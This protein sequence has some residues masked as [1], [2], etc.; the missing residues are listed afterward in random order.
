MSHLMDL[1]A[2]ELVAMIL[3]RQASSHEAVLAAKRRIEQ[4][5][6]ALNAVITPLF[7]EALATAR[8]LDAALAAGEPAGPLHGVPIVIKDL[9]DFRSGVRNTFGCR[10][11]AHFVPNETSAHIARLEHAGAVIMGKTN[12]PEFGHKGTTDNQ[13]FGPTSTPFDLT[14]NAGGSS[15]GSA[16]AVAAGMVPLGQGSDAGGS[17]RIPAAWCGIVGFKPTFGRI[18]LTGGRNAFGTHS[19]FVHVGTLSRTVRD[20]ALMT[21]VML[22]PHPRDPFS[23]PDDGVDLPS[24]V[25]QSLEGMRIAFSPD[26]G[27]FAVDEEVESVVRGAVDALAEAGAAVEEPQFALPCSQEALAALWRRQIGVFYAEFFAALESAGLPLLARAS[28]DIPEEVRTMAAFGQAAS[29]LDA[30]K[31]QW[32]RSEVYN[33][34]QDLFE[35][36]D[37]LVT[38]TVTCLPVKNSSDG[39]TLGPSTVA[40]AEVERCIGWCMTHPV[41]FTGHPAASVPAGLTRDGL[42][43]GMQVIGR[44]YADGSVLAACRAV[45]ERRPWLCQLEKIWKTLPQAAEAAFIKNAGA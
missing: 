4:L 9:F 35:R 13:L 24:A 45:E 20:A 30:R 19:P 7:E 14:R 43:V 6:S 15:G 27:V 36:Y 26:W 39:R 37:F 12:T 5:N 25:N 38:P 18:P 22:G 3:R 44:R 11:L 10:A 42:P 33:V 23:A 16:A 21:Q 28:D 31:D 40:G 1:D 32:L 2:V 29:A 8:R 34:V 41:N 17:V